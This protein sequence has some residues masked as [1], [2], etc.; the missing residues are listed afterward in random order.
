M[1]IAVGGI[2]HETNTFSNVSSDEN[3]FKLYEWLYGE[4]IFEHYAGVRDYIGGMIDQANDEGYTVIPTFSARANPSGVIP[5]ETFQ[6]MKRE[7]IERILEIKEL[8]AVCLALHG[9]GVVEGID[10]LEGELLEELRSRI[11]ENVPIVVTLDLHTNLTDRMVEHASALLGVKEYPHVDSYERGLDAVKVIKEIVVN[12]ITPVMHMTKLPMMIPTTHTLSGPAFEMKL[13]TLEEEKHGDVL[14]C[15]FY[16]SFPHTDVAHIGCA[17]LTTTNN[18]LEL[19]ETTSK[20]L[21][22]DLWDAKSDFIVE[23]PTSTEGVDMA[24]NVEGKP[25]VINETSDN[26]GAGTPGD[27]TNLLKELLHRNLNDSVF[28]C[29]YDPDVAALAHEKGIGATLDVELGG[30]TDYLHGEPLRVTAKVVALADGVF[31]HTNPMMAGKKSNY[32]KT[33]RLVIGQVEVIVISVRTQTFDP[34]IIS[35]TGINPLD[36]KIIALKSSQHFRAGFQDLA[37][38]IITV[39]SPGL[40]SY[41]LDHFEYVNVIRPIYPLD[42]TFEK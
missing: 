33:T 34:E 24:L 27:G 19:A 32:G 12:K 37:K 20:R 1:N 21:A 14:D 28:A 5:F 31:L 38:K 6:T 40:S 4:E 13:K 42:R 7:L 30:K 35:L 23:L 8:D 39:D 29:I 36:Y 16:H 11:D 15:T 26:P 22:Q 2:Q 18:Q 25:V 3:F 17:I 10:D 41:S 9:A